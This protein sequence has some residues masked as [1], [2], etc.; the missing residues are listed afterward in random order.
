MTFQP[1]Y[2]AAMHW[3]V[4]IAPNWYT[5]PIKLDDAGN[6]YGY[7]RTASAMIDTDKIRRLS[8]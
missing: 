7:S 6:P 4:I 5:N 3:G 8:D 2:I 1:V